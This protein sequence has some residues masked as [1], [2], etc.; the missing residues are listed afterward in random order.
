MGTSNTT[1]VAGL[2]V[3]AILVS[4]MATMT[5]VTKST[6]FLT[7]RVGTLGAT[8][9]PTPVITMVEPAWLNFGNMTVG[10]T[11]NATTSIGWG[12]MI[13]SQSNADINISIGADALW[14]RVPYDITSAKY[15]FMCYTGGGRACP[16]GSITSWTNVPIG[17]STLVTAYLNTTSRTTEVN[18]EL[19]VPTDEPWGSKSSTVTFTASLA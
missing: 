19:T 17:G 14:D 18:F 4:A 15:R 10:Q 6:G 16:D 7:A 3:V 11:A 13:D 9:G 12:L 2:L 1:W 8:V 5:V